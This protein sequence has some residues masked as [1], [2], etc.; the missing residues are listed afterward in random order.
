MTILYQ[1]VIGFAKDMAEAIS[2]EVLWVFCGFII[3]VVRGALLLS[4]DL[5]GIKIC[6]EEIHELESQ[7]WNLFLFLYIQYQN[8]KYLK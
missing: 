6:F 1:E 7:K 5:G 2:F 3:D 8:K 4:L